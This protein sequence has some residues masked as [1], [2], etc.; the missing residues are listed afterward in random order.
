MKKTA[1]KRGLAVLLTAL[2]CLSLFPAALAAGEPALQVST[3]EA[4]AGETVEVTVSVVNNPGLSNL[5]MTI[6]YDESVLEL[7]SAAFDDAKWDAYTEDYIT[8]H[9]LQSDPE[10]ETLRELIV[11]RDV[12][13]LPKVTFTMPD[14]YFDDADPLL[15]LTFKVK[16]GAAVGVV[17]SVSVTT[18]KIITDP[19]DPGFADNN[20]AIDKDDNDIELASIA[21]SVTV[22]GDAPPA[23]V[24]YGDV[25]DDE[26]VDVFDLQDLQKFL[27]GWPVTLG[28]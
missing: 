20:P 7:Q 12:A 10:V 22:K 5:P 15:T 1:L 11:Y 26:D 8:S 6:V 27:A 9:G 23:T 28:S 21:G 19:S 17:A 2:L 14:G 25:N 13:H 24:I 16:D 3:A 4:K 18:E